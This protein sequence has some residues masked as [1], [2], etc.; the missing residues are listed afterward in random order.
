MY[1]YILH[2]FCIFLH[3]SAFLL[4]SRASSCAFWMCFC[5]RES[6]HRFLALHQRQLNCL[7]RSCWR[8]LL[9]EILRDDKTYKTWS[10][11]FCQRF[12]A[13]TSWFRLHSVYIMFTMFT[14]AKTIANVNCLRDGASLSGPRTRFTKRREKT[15]KDMKR[16]GALKV[17][18]KSWRILT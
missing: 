14:S 18:E 16:H 10:N 17:R 4:A 1:T 3:H 8:L 5:S 15:W 2:T 6:T 9:W 11:P 12:C 7:S 13:K